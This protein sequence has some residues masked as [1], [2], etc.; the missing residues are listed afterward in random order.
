MLQILQKNLLAT[1]K[2]H[3]MKPMML[4]VRYNSTN[5]TNEPTIPDLSI[6]FAEIL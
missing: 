6:K 4:F 3:L 2:I 1:S 5:S